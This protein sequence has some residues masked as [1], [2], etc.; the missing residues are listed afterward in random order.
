MKRVHQN[1][2]FKQLLAKAKSSKN[3]LTIIKETEEVSSG[4]EEEVSEN[5]ALTL[6]SII[7]SRN[8]QDPTSSIQADKTSILA[9]FEK[10]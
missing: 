9:S 6:S 3:N 4:S 1:P 2:F 7:S 5:L 10:T 8:R